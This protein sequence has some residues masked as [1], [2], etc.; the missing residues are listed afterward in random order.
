[1]ASRKAPPMFEAKPGVASE[2]FAAVEKARDTRIRVSIINEFCTAL[3]KLPPNVAKAELGDN[4]MSPMVFNLFVASSKFHQTVNDIIGH[5]VD[6]F[7]TLGPDWLRNCLV[8]SFGEF[9]NG[10]SS[11]TSGGL[12]LCERILDRKQLKDLLLSDR[13]FSTIYS[14]ISSFLPS[15]IS[16]D[17]LPSAE[18][19]LTFMA[20]AAAALRLVQKVLEAT[21]GPVNRKC[22]MDSCD[23][24]RQFLLSGGEKYPDLYI[25]S[26]GLHAKIRETLGQEGPTSVHLLSMTDKILTQEAPV[27]NCEKLVEEIQNFKL[28]Y[29]AVTNSLMIALCEKLTSGLAQGSHSQQELEEFLTSFTKLWLSEMD[30]VLQKENI[31]HQE[32]VLA[33]SVR[34]LSII[35][36]NWDILTD[37]DRE[38]IRVCVMELPEDFLYSTYGQKTWIS[39]LPVIVPIEAKSL[40]K[41]QE[42]LDRLPKSYF[43]VQIVQLLTLTATAQDI[44]RIV[45]HCPAHRPFLTKSVLPVLIKRPGLLFEV[46]RVLGGEEHFEGYGPLLHALRSTK[47]ENQEAMRREVFQKYIR[48]NAG[49]LAVLMDDVTRLEIFICFCDA[50]DPVSDFAEFVVLV[51]S[52]LDQ[53]FLKFREPFMRA[54]GRFFSRLSAKLSSKSKSKPRPK[55]AAAV[56]PEE[57]V[58]KA[59]DTVAKVLEL[60][61]LLIHQCNPSSSYARRTLSLQIIQVLLSGPLLTVDASGLQWDSTAVTL[62]QQIF[63][64]TFPDNLTLIVDIFSIRPDLQTDQVVGGMEMSQLASMANNKARSCVT[65]DPKV[66]V[67]LDI[68]L[69]KLKYTNEQR[70]NSRMLEAIEQL[71]ADISNAKTFGMLRA[72]RNAPLYGQLFRLRSLLTAVG[73]GDEHGQSTIDA[74]IQACW[75][76]A[77]LVEKALK[78][79]DAQLSMDKSHVLLEETDS[80]GFVVFRVTAQ[81]LFVC[82]W[83]CMREVA[84]LF[85][86]ICCGKATGKFLKDA[87]KVWIFDWM[88]FQ[89]S[90]TRH[91]GAFEGLA[92]QIARIA[93]MFDEEKSLKGMAFV[94]KTLDWVLKELRA[95][96]SPLCPENSR[97]SAGVPRLLAILFVA[98]SRTDTGLEAFEQ[99]MVDLMD[100]ASGDVKRNTDDRV[101]ALDI[102]EA[103]FRENALNEAAECFI[104]DG[105]IV[106]CDS[107]ASSVWS[108]RNSAAGLFTALMQRVFGPSVRR[109]PEELEW[110]EAA[111]PAHRFFGKYTGLFDY[112]KTC[113]QRTVEQKDKHVPN[114]RQTSSAYCALLLLQ[115]LYPL[116]GDP[117]Y[118]TGVTEVLEGCLAHRDLRLRQAAAKATVLFLSE[119]ELHN[120]IKKIKPPFRSLQEALLVALELD[121]V[122]HFL[123]QFRNTQHAFYSKLL[124]YFVDGYMDS[125]Y[126][127]K[128]LALRIF[129]KFDRW[130]DLQ[131]EVTNQKKLQGAMADFSEDAHGWDPGYTTWASNYAAALIKICQRAM[132]T[133]SVVGLD[134]TVGMVVQKIMSK[135]TSSDLAVRLLNSLDSNAVY[136]AG[137]IL[138]NEAFRSYLLDLS[139][140][141]SSALLAAKIT[142]LT[143]ALEFHTGEWQMK[144]TARDTFWLNIVSLLTTLLESELL[145]VGLRCLSRIR[146]MF[147]KPEDDDRT[148]Q[149]VEVI[150]RVMEEVPTL[151]VRMTCADVVPCPRI[152]EIG[153]GDGNEMALLDRWLIILKLL[154]DDSQEVRYK[155]AGSFT[156]INEGRDRPCLPVRTISLALDSMVRSCTGRNLLVPLI[157][158]VALSC[159]G[160]NDE[161]LREEPE[162]SEEEVFRPVD[163]HEYQ[164]GLWLIDRL[165]ESVRKQDRSSQIDDVLSRQSEAVNQMVEDVGGAAHF[166]MNTAFLDNPNEYSR[167]VFRLYCQIVALCMIDVVATF[168]LSIKKKLMENIDEL[169]VVSGPRANSLVLQARK[170]L[171]LHSAIVEEVN[172]SLEHLSL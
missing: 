137:F 141:Q 63:W 65:N 136:S 7:I 119:S 80:E 15:A 40:W 20:N 104:G 144:S 143:S 73:V 110:R 160:E 10:E 53:Q 155:M 112:I 66:A 116:V 69:D 146:L 64:E 89:L 99:T 41:T 59:A 45:Q 91:T 162:K 51:E 125:S 139:P 21:S 26:V 158:R 171:I 142:L 43:G 161:L 100:V 86:E 12:K 163:R 38:R 93:Q 156:E 130:T 34:V 48:G 123:F 75:Q 4:R 78:E 167:A 105:F 72:A 168:P 118:L 107:V 121:R 17:G 83:H 101:R 37:E 151:E 68:L 150:E 49:V 90:V 22:L 42:I 145:C 52:N 3:F 61:H 46:L 32:A 54:L 31:S 152:E 27:Q 81:Q 85:G 140:K 23:R 24:L 122:A 60:F 6:T 117:L 103:L 70:P 16:K 127:T 157:H 159:L 126:S 47:V 5:V 120:I 35:V 62:T 79:N 149:F 98:L 88:V 67:S 138:Q 11:R 92:E 94:N 74:I 132:Q 102:L 50:A 165:Y 172:S 131:V 8:R 1:M 97:K 129:L 9:F 114:D 77:N 96:S 153:N 55:K 147:R 128:D 33:V 2:F 57:S 154:R 56:A 39:L 148:A 30:D 58:A 36:N 164:E 106:A 14:F 19:E 28:A 113:L 82:C 169:L 115:R 25:S 29:P 109:P 44:A 76:T 87:E 133:K 108:V 134:Q 170:L 95:W 124:V 18:A 84:M 111:L 71:R 135:S 166:L 13:N